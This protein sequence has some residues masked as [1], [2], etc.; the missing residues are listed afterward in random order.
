[1]TQRFERRQPGTSHGINDAKRAAETGGITLEE[2]ERCFYQA[3]VDDYQQDWDSLR[4]KKRCICCD[5]AVAQSGLHQY[6]G[7]PVY[8][9]YVLINTVYP[10]TPVHVYYISS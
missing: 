9:T 10:K 7:L 1:M 2:L 5:H 8:L 6:L 3:I 4:R